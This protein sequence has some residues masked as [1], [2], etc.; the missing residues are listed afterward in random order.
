MESINIFLKAGQLLSFFLLHCEGEIVSFW[1]YCFKREVNFCFCLSSEIW[2]EWLYNFNESRYLQLCSLDNRKGRLKGISLFYN[3]Y[4]T[5]LSHHTE[6]MPEI[7][8]TFQK[9]LTI[10]KLVKIHESHLHLRNNIV[11]LHFRMHFYSLPYCQNKYFTP[12][13]IN[14][15]QNIY[16]N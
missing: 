9:S 5:H 12:I 8:F 3:Y 13:N 15:P 6:E 10:T 11:Y 16:R 1:G 2:W 4:L 7:P 14:F